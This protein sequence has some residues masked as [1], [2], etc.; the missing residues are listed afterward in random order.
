LSNGA[1]AEEIRESQVAQLIL[2]DHMKK[3]AIL[4]TLVGF[5]VMSLVALAQTHV[6]KTA[7][8]LLL[9]A[10]QGSRDLSLIDPAAGKQLTTIPVEGVT[11]HEVATSPDGKTAYVPIYGDAGVGR[12]GTDGSKLSVIDLAS[13]KVVHTID[14]GHGVRPHC[15]VYDRNS[16]MLY[17]TTE[18]DKTV[19]IIDPKTLKIVGSIPTGQ[20]QSH[21]LAL[22]R[23]GSRGYTANVGPGTVSVLD[24]KA[25][26]TLTIIPISTSTQRIAISR[27][28]SMVFTADQAKPQLAVIDTATNKVKTWVPLP[29]VGYGTAPTLDGRWLLVA[30][31]GAKGVAVV[32]L[33]TM[34]VAKTIA[35]PD[36]PAEILIDPNGKT[37]FV[38]CN[39]KNQIA[40]IDLGQWKVTQLIDAG[41]TAD[42]LAWAK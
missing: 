34:Q 27:D 1:C 10:N 7:S 41:K 26:K 36:G 20:E 35:V 4:R 22:S 18:L 25:R 37:A 40:V 12:P 31:R 24:M 6:E 19:S 15:A 23:D 38:A 39:A 30:M 42:G 33:K 3:T 16:G 28:D 29:A 11:G 5:S 17:V 32:D 14:F 8:P 9:V 2:V 21:M 13:R